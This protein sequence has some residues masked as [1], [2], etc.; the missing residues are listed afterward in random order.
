MKSPKVL[1]FASLALILGLTFVSLMPATAEARRP[2]PTIV[3]IAASDPG[4]FSTLVAAVQKAELVDALNGNRH[5]TVFAPTNTA[6]DNAA[7]AVLGGG[8]TG[9]D[10]VD[11]LD[12]DTL[13][14]ILLYH[15]TRGDRQSQSLFPP[16]S[17][18]MLNGDRTVT[19]IE[20]GKPFINDSEIII[21][22][23]R[24]SNGIVHVINAVLLPPS[25]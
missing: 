3:E 10:L 14:N 4:N 18:K 25:N 23:I 24:A 2:G 5:F 21:K 20:D 13:T 6:F 9:T 1:L 16:K 12:K 11:A 8:A 15:V 22:D 19:S 7:E 17:V